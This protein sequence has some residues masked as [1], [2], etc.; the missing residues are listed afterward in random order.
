MI[1]DLSSYDIAVVCFVSL[2]AILLVLACTL[3]SI[4]FIFTLQAVIQACLN[5]VTVILEIGV[6]T[7]AAVTS[8]EYNMYDLLQSG[9]M[10]CMD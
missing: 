10:T 5:V 1:L 7:I 4:F 3:S 6:A 8:G 9:L 2:F